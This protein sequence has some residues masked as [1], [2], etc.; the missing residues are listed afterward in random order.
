[1]LSHAE[2]KRDEPVM[3]VIFAALITQKLG[4]SSVECQLSRL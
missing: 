2:L 4:D 1:M 3:A